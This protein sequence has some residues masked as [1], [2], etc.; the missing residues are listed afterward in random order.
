MDNQKK[1]IGIIPSR[2]ASTRLPNKP[3]AD[4]CGKAL[5]Q[6]V[7]EATCQSNLLQRVVIATDSKEIADLCFA[8]GAEY[9]MTESELPS[10]TD[11]I[12]R[13][14]DILEENADIVVNIQ[15]DEPLLNG[16]II[17]NLLR[18]FVDSKADVG[19]LIKKI[20]N[21]EDIL[22]SSV[23]KVGLNPDMTAITFSR[24]PIPNMKEFPIENWLEKAIFWKHIGIY[25]Y[26]IDAL[27]KFV[28][29]PVAESEK[30][31]RLEQL[32][33]LETGA[34]YLCV[35]TDANLIGVDTMEDLERV[36]K[37]FANR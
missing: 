21:L 2:L 37:I 22:D 24:E 23:V 17:D 25:A 13:A 19:T 16:Q 28:S 29:L 12:K 15:G 27:K 4:I 5:I 7:W 32:R 18:N 31:E 26:K 6:R 10:G 35:E 14:Y 20:D 1:I 36:R 8:L 9:V 11:R 34:K 3:L 33:L 30:K